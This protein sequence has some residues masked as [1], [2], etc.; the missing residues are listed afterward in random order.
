MG[1]CSDVSV[2]QTAAAQITATLPIT[3]GWMAFLKA[4]EW[5]VEVRICRISLAQML[6][7]AL[8]KKQSIHFLKKKKKTPLVYPWLFL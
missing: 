6:L 8:Y 5:S 2:P 3:Y 4:F 1:Q 7:Y